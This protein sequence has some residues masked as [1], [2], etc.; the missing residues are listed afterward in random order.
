MMEFGTALSV[1]AETSRGT[2][3]NNVINAGSNN[4]NEN[5]ENRVDLKDNAA[6]EARLCQVM[7]VMQ[8]RT[9]V[10]GQAY[11]DHADK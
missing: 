8:Q 1:L 10:I 11:G 3:Y 7:N 5:N 6:S 4:N 2:G 9:G